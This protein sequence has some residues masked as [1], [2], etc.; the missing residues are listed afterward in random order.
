[1]TLSVRS[2][3]RLFHLK[4]PGRNISQDSALL[5][6]VYLEREAEAVISKASAIHDKENALRKQMGE[7]P[8]VRLSPKHVRMAIEGKFIGE[9][10]D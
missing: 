2:I 8:K 3:M 10:A 1:M 6:K 5:L 7:R 4:A 9:K